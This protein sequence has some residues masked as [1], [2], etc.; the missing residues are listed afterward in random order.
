LLCNWQYIHKHEYLLREMQDRNSNIYCFQKS[1][2]ATRTETEITRRRQQRVIKKN[3]VRG[4]G[5]QS[6]GTGAREHGNESVI[7][8]K[9]GERLY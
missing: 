7:S 5:L 8:A 3:E 4:H 6:P 9:G 2:K 1:D